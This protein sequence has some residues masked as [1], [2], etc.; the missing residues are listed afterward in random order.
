M[1]I[2]KLFAAKNNIL[3]LL[4][5]NYTVILLY[6]RWLLGVEVESSINEVQTRMPGLCLL[7]KRVIFLRLVLT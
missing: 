5:E 1:S 4:Q 3:D 2:I 6:K 7:G